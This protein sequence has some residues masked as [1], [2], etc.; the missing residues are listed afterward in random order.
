[1]VMYADTLFDLLAAES[2]PSAGPVAKMVL[3]G[4]WLLVFALALIV[5]RLLLPSQDRPSLRW[6][7]Q[8]WV[9]TLISYVAGL[10]AVPRGLLLI[11]VLLFCASV[12]GVRIAS[13]AL[14]RCFASGPR[15]EA[16]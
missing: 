9:A 1:M 6:L 10:A 11:D 13:T 14:A 4:L 15:V 2:A 12:E 7:N 3:P 5:T 16:T 8:A